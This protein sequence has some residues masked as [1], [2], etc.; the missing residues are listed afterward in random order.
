MFEFN[1]QKKRIDRSR[2]RYYDTLLATR[3]ILL[4]SGNRIY[5]YDFTL[6]SRWYFTC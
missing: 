2:R 5:I 3:C 6:H 4:A 1:W